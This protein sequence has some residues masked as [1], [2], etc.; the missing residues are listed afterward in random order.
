M[1]NIDSI[2]FNPVKWAEV[3]REINS[4]RLELD[5][6]VFKKTDQERKELSL[7]KSLYNSNKVNSKFKV[8]RDNLIEN[9]LRSKTPKFNLSKFEA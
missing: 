9:F 7:Q 6:E 3:Q 8:E 1:K 5:R 2:Y 4:K